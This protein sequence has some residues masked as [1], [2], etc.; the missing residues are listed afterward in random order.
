MDAAAK[1]GLELVKYVI[2]PSGSRFTA[3]AFATG[4]LSAFGHNPTIGMRDFDGEIQFVP[5]TYENASV[6]VTVRRNA[7]EGPT[8]KM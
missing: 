5:D 3:Q 8:S 7:M 1:R 4:M 2:D 6:R